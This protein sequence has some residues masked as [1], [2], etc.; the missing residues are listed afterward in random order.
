M[1][2]IEDEEI[3]TD[4]QYLKPIFNYFAFIR[5][6]H[7]A[8]FFESVQQWCKKYKDSTLKTYLS[9]LEILFTYFAKYSPRLIS[10]DLSIVFMYDNKF[11]KLKE[12]ILSN[13]KVSNWISQIKEINVGPDL[14]E[15]VKF[16]QIFDF[17]T[18][19]RKV[20]K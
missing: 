12:F 14:I 2:L 11:N 18:N 6:F 20:N 1:S 9:V 13:V 8:N 10:L 15:D 5:H 19:V 3:L 7:C 17:C 4:K 16:F